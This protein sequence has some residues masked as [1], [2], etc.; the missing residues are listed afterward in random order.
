MFPTYL[1]SHLARADAGLISD[2][3][4]ALT[5]VQILWMNLVTDGLPAI[6]LGVDPGDPDLMDRKPRK[7]NESIF[8]KDVKVYL[9]AIPI[10][11]TVLLLIAYLLTSA[12][13]KRGPSTRSQNTIAYCHD[14]NAVSHSSLY[15]FAKVSCVQ[16]RTLQ[17]QVPMVCNSFI[18][19][20]TTSNPIR[21]RSTI[22]L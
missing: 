2:A 20:T 1:G 9:T 16:G 19:C 8:S 13:D 21:A 10:I 11:M 17:E 7:P 4:I 3:A 14:S 15:A 22:T 18:I 12:M 5:A 6:A